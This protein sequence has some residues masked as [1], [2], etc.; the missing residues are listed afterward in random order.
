M[1]KYEIN[2]SVSISCS[3]EGLSIEDERSRR[4]ASWDKIGVT[5]DIVER[6]LLNGNGVQLPARTISALVYAGVLIEA[7]QEIEADG[8]TPRHFG[9]FAARSSRPHDALRRI[10]DSH[11]L[12]LGVGGTGG[13]V[14]QHLVGAG[15]TQ[16]TLVDS[17]LVE[18][19]NFNR[20]YLWTKADVGRNKVDTA[21]EY[22]LERT[23]PAEVNVLRM[24]LDDHKTLNQVLGAAPFSIVIIA[25]DSPYGIQDLVYER[26]GQF[27]LAAIGGAVGNLRGHWGPIIAPHSGPCWI[28]WKAGLESRKAANR[29]QGPV[30]VTR[31]SF[32]PTNSLISD[33]IAHHALLYL[34]GAAN[35]SLVGVQ[36]AIDFDTLEVWRHASL[37]CSHSQQ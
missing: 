19:S 26:S 17:D 37:P 22:I 1:K 28:C 29:P 32:G 35:E 4:R 36:T 11:V 31:W 34:A 10:R 30:E 12:L 6:I 18:E 5:R 16:F 25:I 27:G 20:Q 14:L 23:N 8:E 21:R 7:D 3:N 13:A 2:P 9:Y 24:R 15:V 33:M